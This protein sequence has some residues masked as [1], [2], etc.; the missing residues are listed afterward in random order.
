[1]R[2]FPEIFADE[3]RIP[4][5]VAKRPDLALLIRVNRADR[6]TFYTVAVTGGEYETFGLK[7]KTIAWS[8]EDVQQFASDKSE[9]ALTVG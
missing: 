3:A 4:D 6:H 2:R 7:L 1:M 8:A 5:C 9:A